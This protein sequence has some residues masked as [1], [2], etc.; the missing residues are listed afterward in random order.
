MGM[1]HE[2]DVVCRREALSFGFLEESQEILVPC[3]CEGE[4]SLVPVVRRYGHLRDG[5]RAEVLP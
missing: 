4:E 1:P 5:I 2:V 3:S